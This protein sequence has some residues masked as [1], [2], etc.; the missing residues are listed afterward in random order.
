MIQTTSSSKPAGLSRA[1]HQ[2]AAS[3][4]PVILSGDYAG[5]RTTTGHPVGSPGLRRSLVPFKPAI[6]VEEF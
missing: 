3:A 5:H 6:I 1:D 2:A 4:T